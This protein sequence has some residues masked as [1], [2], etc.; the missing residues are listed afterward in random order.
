MTFEIFH[1]RGFLWKALSLG[2]VVVK[3]DGLLDNCEIH[4]IVDLMDSGS[5]RS[6][7]SKLEY[8]VR[9]RTPIL[10]PEIKDK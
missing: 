1:Y 9:L 5:R 2:K 8:Y 4:E 6:N 10:K 3:L 7:G